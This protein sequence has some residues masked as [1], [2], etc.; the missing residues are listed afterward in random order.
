MDTLIPVQFSPLPP[1]CLSYK[2]CDVRK[3]NGGSDENCAGIKLS[4]NSSRHYDNRGTYVIF[5]ESPILIVILVNM[6]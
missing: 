3:Q 2:A 1:S 6:I 5:N 4:S